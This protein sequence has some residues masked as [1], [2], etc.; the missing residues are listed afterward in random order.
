MARYMNLMSDYAFK[1][2]FGSEK[3]KNVLIRFL[4]HILN[5]EDKIVDV[6]FQDK[7][8]I[9]E[10]S[11]DKRVVFDIYC[12]THHGHHIIVEMQRS[13]QPT[14]SDRALTYCCNALMH[15]VKRGDKA[16]NLS[17]VYGI[18]IM[19]FHLCGHKPVPFREVGLYDFTCQKRF[20]HRLN[21]YFLD[22]TM[23][24]RKTFEECETDVERW[25]FLF[26]NI[27]SME[28]K[29]KGYPEFDELFEAADMSHLANEE[30][31]AYS[32]SRQKILDDREGVR[33]WGEIVREEALEEG[34]NEGRNEGRK[35]A[36]TS[37]IGTM[38]SKGMSLEAI[39]D[40]LGL[41]HDEVCAL[42]L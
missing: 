16:Y 34:R 26:K 5:P 18:F 28:S 30:V 32:Q 35:D 11:G 19:D 37:I 24:D 25:L 1:R 17:D 41:S 9:P 6:S 20:S 29:P 40:M 3:H 42:A 33:Q 12:V 39:A 8:A 23:M 7:E 14:F 36:Y 27:E 22:L 13:I 2:T 21:N 4:N 15:Q 38:R 10:T 31:V